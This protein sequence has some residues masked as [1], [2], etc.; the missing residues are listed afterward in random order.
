[1]RFLLRRTV[2]YL[3]TLW[4]A[5]TINFFLPRMMKGNPIEAYMANNPGQV[6]PAAIRSLR[7]LFGFKSN[8]SLVT[9]Y[10][11]YWKLLAHGNLGDSFS[12]GLAPVTEVI[13]SALPWTIGLV[14]LATLISF[15][16]GTLLGAIV[17]WRRGSG[18][19]LIVPVATFFGAVPYFWMG[20]IVIA[21]FSSR[22]GWFPAS[23]AYDIG[24][25]PGWNLTFVW[26]VIRHGILPAV[27]IVLTSLGG[28]VLGMRNMMVTV[29]DE[30][31]VTVAQAKGLSPMRVMFSYAA[32]NAVLPQIQSFALA[33]GFIVSGTLVM[34]LVFSYPGIGNLLLE[35]TSAKDYP[36][37]QG[38]FLVITLAVL[39]ANVLADVA[40][41]ILDPRT[42]QMEA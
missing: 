36:L 5:V 32:R 18:A 33:L 31:Y 39:I 16:L 2:F 41:A 17:G 29:L 13:R 8:Q 9:Q 11:D 27:T 15:A 14:G 7:I 35:A 12:S 21:I 4:A 3:F 34:E 40:Y 1:V 22:L 23:H 19:D 26:Q 38:I 6:T 20:L 37:M 28:W 30:D 10:L 24:Y 25:W 42:R